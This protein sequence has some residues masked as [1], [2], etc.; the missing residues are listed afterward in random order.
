MRGGIAYRLIAAK[1]CLDICYEDLSN[2]L[3]IDP[4]LWRERVNP[5]LMLPCVIYRRRHGELVFEGTRRAPSH[6]KRIVLLKFVL[7]CVCSTCKLSL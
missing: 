4:V 2:T 5:K 3:S 7:D 1:C 6:L